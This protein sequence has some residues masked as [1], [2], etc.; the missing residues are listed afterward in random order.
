M[1]T[2][3]DDIAVVDVE[4]TGL[5]L[6]QDI[7]EIAVAIGEQP[8]QVSMV[9]HSLQNANPVALSLNGYWDRFS[10]NGV[11][12]EADIKFREM[13]TGKTIVGANPAFDADRLRR[14]WGAQV[15]H[16]RMVDIESMAAVLFDW[17]KPKGLAGVIEHLASFGKYNLPNPDHSAAADVVATREVYRILRTIGRERIP[18][19]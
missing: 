6:D 17:D 15:W 3:P 1:I 16:Y 2:I 10:W 7:W 9:P 11:N 4:T 18:V 12:R 19:V 5:E 13:L 14:R 8:V